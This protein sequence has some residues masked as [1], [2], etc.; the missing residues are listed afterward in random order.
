MPECD[1]NRK[2]VGQTLVNTG[3]SRF[4]GKSNFISLW[5]VGLVM[6]GP[7]GEFDSEDKLCRVEGSDVTSFHN[8]DAVPFKLMAAALEVPH[9]GW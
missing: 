7:E 8:S 9:P 5:S 4:C 6:T 1:T 3:G 2:R